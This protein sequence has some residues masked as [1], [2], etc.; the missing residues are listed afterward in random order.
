MEVIKKQTNSL[1]P[2]AS[3]S[4][5]YE[6]EDFDLDILTASISNDGIL[7]PLIV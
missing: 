4:A 2:S 7:E 6:G 5:I 1:K 3:H